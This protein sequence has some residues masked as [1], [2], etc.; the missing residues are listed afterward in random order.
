[1]ELMVIMSWSSWLQTCHQVWV[2]ERKSK[3]VKETGEVADD[4][5]LA[6]K[7]TMQEKRCGQKGHLAGSCPTAGK[8]VGSVD[9]R[10]E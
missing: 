2:H 6:R 1:M 8:G 7:Q 4:H 10:Q 5:V 9:R 3:T